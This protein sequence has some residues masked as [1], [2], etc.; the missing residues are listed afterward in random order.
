VDGGQV[1]GEVAAVAF[2]ALLEATRMMVHTGPGSRQSASA[3]QMFEPEV[4]DAHQA[5]QNALEEDFRAG[6]SSA[7]KDSRFDVTSVQARLARCAAEPGPDARERSVEMPSGEDVRGGKMSPGSGGSRQAADAA[8]QRGGVEPDIADRIVDR[9][10][11]MRTR[12]NPQ[13]SPPLPTNSDRAVVEASLAGG[14]PV[15]VSAGAAVRTGTTPNGTVAQ[16]VGQILGAARGGE[17]ES[18]RAP[19]PPAAA[20]QTRS[21]AQQSRSDKAPTP[22]GRTADQASARAS[23]RPKEAARTEFDRL[24][25]SIRLRT[26]AARSSARLRLHPPELGRVL[27]DVRME[28]DEL[29]IDVRTETAEAKDL[30]HDRAARLRAALEQQGIHVGRLEVTGN[31]DEQAAGGASTNAG[32]EPAGGDGKTDRHTDSWPSVERNEREEAPVT[33]VSEAG[34]ETAVVGERRLDVRI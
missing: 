24:V 2:G 6:K 27:V 12:L 17:V 18:A 1:E 29:R 16:Q 13:P 3:G 10:E 34:M 30:L 8:L 23:D 28:G 26:S 9:A 5:R 21:T 22:K 20:G 15:A 31:L 7:L 32:F 11:P 14:R 4:H 25:R 33:G 19:A